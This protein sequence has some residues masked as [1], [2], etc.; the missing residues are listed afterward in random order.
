MHC[1]TLL[2]LQN[3]WHI[4][5]EASSRKTLQPMGLYQVAH[6]PHKYFQLLGIA[7]LEVK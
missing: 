1:W 3:I 6:L 4:D 7:T 5:L 2:S